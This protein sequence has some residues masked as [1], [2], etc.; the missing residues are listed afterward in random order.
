M[1]DL[2]LEKIS[3]TFG[4]NQVIKD[5]NLKVHDGEFIVFVGPSGC[6]KSTMLRIIAGLEEQTSGEVFIGGQNV[7]HLPPA[8]RGIAMVFQ[9]YALYPHLTVEG[10]MRIGLKQS[11]AKKEYIDERVEQVAN[12][13]QLDALLNRRPSELSGGQRQR[14]AIG[15]ALVRNPD[16]FLFDEP[17]SNLD[18]ALRSSV[19][20]EIA[21]LHNALK[22]TMIY[23]THDQ[24][25]AMTLAD[26][27]VVFHDG[28]IQQVGSPLELYE[29]PSN[30]FVAGFIGSPKMNFFKGDAKSNHFEYNGQNLPIM[31]GHIISTA[32]IELGVRPQHFMIDESSLSQFKA[33]VIYTEY[34]GN[35]SHIHLEL[36]DGKNII[37]AQD[38]NDGA[39]KR[40]Y[41]KG[42]EVA[43]AVDAR[44]CHFFKDEK[45]I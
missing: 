18:A 32:N 29:H 22:A 20:F 41:H 31:N 15:R 12:I 13:L 6:G 28:I 19:R 40:K 14:V 7:G 44:H 11:G 21:E 25:E 27:I 2:S 34:L 45:R 8:K 1:A 17:L 9:S 38:N 36:T 4:T 43:L 42:Q 37:L 35:E 24:V 16:V 39:Q 3:K 23:V 33:K 5:V 26:R 10:N 30:K